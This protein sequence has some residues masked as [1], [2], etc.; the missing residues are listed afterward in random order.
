MGEAA[1]SRGSSAT[2][3]RCGGDNKEPPFA[4]RCNGACWMRR[5]GELHNTADTSLTLDFTTRGCPGL[6][7][8][9]YMAYR[10]FMVAYLCERAFF[11]RIP[12]RCDVGTLLYS[13][14]FDWRIT[15]TLGEAK[16][17][18][19]V[20]HVLGSQKVRRLNQAFSSLP[21]QHFFPAK[22]MVVVAG[23]M[24]TTPIHILSNPHL[25][26]RRS[27]SSLFQLTPAI[28]HGCIHHLLFTPRA[29][30]QRTIAQHLST[31]GDDA[32]GV[33]IRLGDT[34]SGLVPLRKNHRDKRD[35]PHWQCADEAMMHNRSGYVAADSAY[36]VP[37]WRV[38]YGAVRVS[39]E[40]G[41]PLH[42]A[43]SKNFSASNLR[44]VVVDFQVICHTA[45]RFL[46]ASSSFSTEA[47]YCAFGERSW[48][49]NHPRCVPFAPHLD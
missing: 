11:L 45:L 3:L 43:H 48:T 15:G 27:T 34:L 22:H 6:G 4:A 30:L 25:V 29:A 7:N 16:T 19:T 39:T 32:V 47:F 13:P 33:H 2:D 8:L 41:N 46:T 40:P 38:R 31:L 49:I 37:R 20:A 21:S 26:D 17:L 35:L 28:R 10:W 14:F 1:A 23:T 12:E 5:Y 44:K 36:Q 9:F 18:V 42:T 24:D